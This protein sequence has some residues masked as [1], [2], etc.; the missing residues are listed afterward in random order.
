MI[1]GGLKGGQKTITY[2]EISNYDCKISK[3]NLI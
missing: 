2:I 3:P 1:K